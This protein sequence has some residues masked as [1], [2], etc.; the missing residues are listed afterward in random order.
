MQGRVQIHFSA[1]NIYGTHIPS[2]ARLMPANGFVQP[3]TGIISFWSQF[4]GG[5][6]GVRTLDLRVANAA[7]SQLSYEPVFAQIKLYAP[8]LRGALHAAQPLV[9]RGGIE[10]PLPA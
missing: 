10:P 8:L 5:P 6:E 9:T 1:E 7:L 4:A 3:I 2:F